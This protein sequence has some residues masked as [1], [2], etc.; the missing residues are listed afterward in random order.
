MS[1]GTS[2]PDL[3]LFPVRVGTIVPVRIDFEAFARPSEAKPPQYHDPANVAF[4]VAVKYQV[5]ETAGVVVIHAEASFE[6]AQGTPPGHEKAEVVTA[7][8]PYRLSV[9]A[10][11]PF[12]YDPNK[13][14][15]DEVTKWCAKGAFFVVSPYLR[16]L[17]FSITGQSGFPMITL[18]LVEVPVLREK[19][20]GKPKDAT[21]SN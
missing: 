11:A 7:K 10:A 2:N 16:L 21:Q 8:P 20:A 17:V 4:K 15:K 9:G 5:D 13:I 6:D 19:P 1:E 18:P 12:V 14:S 3:E